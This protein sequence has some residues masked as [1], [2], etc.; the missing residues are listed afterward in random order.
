M[1]RKTETTV[2]RNQDGSMNLQSE[3]TVIHDETGKL[4]WEHSQNSHGF[5]CLY[6]R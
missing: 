6:S 1:I 5:S 3:D 4:L 2:F